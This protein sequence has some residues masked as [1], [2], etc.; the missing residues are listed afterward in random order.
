MKGAP[1]KKLRTLLN[2]FIASVQLDNA[3]IPAGLM[4][5][6]EEADLGL[7]G[8]AEGLALVRRVLQLGQLLAHNLEL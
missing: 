5:L 1:T 2:I 4:D 3:L 8:L 7:R 6:L